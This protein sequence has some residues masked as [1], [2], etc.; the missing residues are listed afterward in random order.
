MDYSKFT[1]IEKN[2][3]HTKTILY[4]F[5]IKKFTWKQRNTFTNIWSVIAYLDKNSDKQLYFTQSEIDDYFEEWNNIVINFNKYMQFC[6][7][8]WKSDERKMEAFLSRWLR[9]L[10]DE[11]KQKIKETST[12]DDILK[13]INNYSEEEKNTFI[14]E[15]TTEKNIIDIIKK[16]DI[17]KQKIILEKLWKW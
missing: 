17:E 3:Y 7:N 1:Y 9:Y 12:K 4:D 16:L 13:M 10:T 6:E 2:D 14:A 11:E 8:I 15:N 5:D